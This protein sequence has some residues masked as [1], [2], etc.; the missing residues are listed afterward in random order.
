MGSRVSV[1]KPDCC[2]HH[3]PKMSD[4]D[5]NASDDKWT[6]PAALPEG[7]QK[8]IIQEAPSGNWRNPKKGDVP[9]V[10]YVGTLEA[11]GS[12][13]DSSRA[14]EAP[15]TFTLGKNEV[16]KGWDLGLPR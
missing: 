2:A 7:V 14:R 12:E 8:E 16:I 15:V 10:H 9:T 13:F 5:S 1:S 3:W 4:V 6:P 11:D